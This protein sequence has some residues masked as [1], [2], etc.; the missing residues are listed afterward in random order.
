M[1]SNMHKSADLADHAL[2]RSLKHA[3]N[4]HRSP[5]EPPKEPGDIEGYLKPPC[6]QQRLLKCASL[7][8]PNC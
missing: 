3:Q 1:P 8:E 5:P 6:V 2:R 7:Q 4:A